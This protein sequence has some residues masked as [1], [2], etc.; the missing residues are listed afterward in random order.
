MV[1]L[2]LGLRGGDEYLEFECSCPIF[3]SC[4]ESGPCAEGGTGMSSSV[5]SLLTSLDGCSAVLCGIGLIRG[6]RG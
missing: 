1:R 4:M 5:T 6:K 3:Y 2:I